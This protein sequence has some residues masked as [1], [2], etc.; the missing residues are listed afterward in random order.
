MA[1][2]KNPEQA[3]KPI[4]KQ[5]DTED[6]SIGFFGWLATGAAVVATVVGGVTIGKAILAKINS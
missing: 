1:Q 6:E 4:K 3:E 5:K 2:K